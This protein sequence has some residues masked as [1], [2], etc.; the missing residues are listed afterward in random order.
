MNHVSDILKRAGTAS[1]RHVPVSA[2]MADNNIGSVLVMENNKYLGLI[3]ERDYS[4]K[5]ILKGK[6]Y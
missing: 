6:F 4:R 2:V 5:V 3:T 1:S